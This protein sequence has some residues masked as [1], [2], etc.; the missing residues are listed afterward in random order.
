MPWTLSTITKPRSIR[1]QP[2]HFLAVQLQYLLFQLNCRPKLRRSR[3]WGEGTTGSAG[4]TTR[5]R[6]KS[7]LRS[8]RPACWKSPHSNRI[9]E[10]KCSSWWILCSC[11][12]SVL[13]YSSSSPQIA[14]GYLM[15]CEEDG[16][17]RIRNSFFVMVVVQL[18]TCWTQEI[19]YS[20]CS[21]RLYQVVIYCDLI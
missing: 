20:L 18:K 12:L 13:S 2:A 19:F 14:L 1:V 3:S 15:S 17:D 16:R 7:V 6:V 21:C 5:R 8:K 9:S 10:Q 4:L 11:L